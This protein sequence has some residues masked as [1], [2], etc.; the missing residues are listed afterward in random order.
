[1]A[2]NVDSG[3]PAPARDARRPGALWPQISVPLLAVALLVSFVAT[4]DRRPAAPAFSGELAGLVVT[5]RVA[6]DSMHR[7][8]RRGLGQANLGGK[9]STAGISGGHFA[10]R[11]G[12]AVVG[13]ITRAHAAAATLYRTSMRDGITRMLFSVSRP[14]RGGLGQY[15][16]L[17]LRKQRNGTAYRVRL[18]VAPNGVLQ[19]GLSRVRGRVERRI[20][21]TITL[22]VRAPKGRRIVL[23]GIVSGTSPVTLGARA[24]L[25][26]RAA[27]NWQVS[28]TDRSSARLT[29]AGSVGFWTYT[30]RTSRAGTVTITRLDAWSIR[31][32][33]AAPPPSSHDKPSTTPPTPTPTPRPTPSP[34][35]TP[36]PSPSDP[37]PDPTSTP[38]PTPTPTPTPPGEPGSSSTAG[39][40]PVGTASYP[41]SAG[42]LFVSSATGSDSSP[43]TASAPLATVKAAIA[44]AASGQMIVLRGGTYHENLF[45]GS[46]KSVTIEN[47]PDEAVWFDGTTAVPSWSPINGVWVASGWTASFDHSASF[48]KGSDAGGFVNP[49]YPMAAHP[50]QVFIDGRALRQVADGATPGP[51]EFSVNQTAHTL[52]IGSNPSG[53]S[54]RASDLAQAF[55]VAGRITLRGVGVRGYAT[56]LPQIGT[57]YLGGSVGGDVLENVV[58]SDNAT[59]GISA[60]ARNCLLAHVTAQDNGMSGIHSNHG[61]GLVVT[62]SLMT[63]NNTEHFNAAPSAGGIK[64]T[65][66]DGVTIRNNL[67]SENLGI[68]GIWTDVTVSHFS[69]TGNTVTGNGG[70]YG[71]ITELSDTGVVADNVESG[72]KY[73]YTAFDTGN[74]RVFNNSF[75]GNSVWDIG[76]SQDARRNS[77]ANTSATVPWLVRNI[78]VANNVLNSAAGYQFYALDKATHTAVSSMNVTVDGNEFVASSG[79]SSTVMAGWGGADNVTVNRYRTP[80]QLNAGVGK[81]W[82]NVQLSGVQ[83]YAAD[84]AGGSSP[85][86]PLPADIAS[87]IGQPA[88]TRHVGPF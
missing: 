52:S 59:Q 37:T 22:P 83:A 24:W 8:V 50:D 78:V 51:D 79:T 35:P 1:M 15:V 74:V 87:E 7:T 17:E 28:Y 6:A 32:V 42:A 71:I 82:T 43:G 46:T 13:P 69:I 2:P 80:D 76:L 65:N 85:A 60:S 30:S 77:D 27:P 19:L 66:A 40:V 67:I 11:R 44:R 18:R 58:V 31:H 21:R 38:A 62:D 86:V 57:I 4:G 73:G 34:T 3:I 41:V 70:P 29:R 5:G 16:D 45:V 81:S 88:G 20:G 61:S 25:T 48:T 10:V 26:G 23:E 54:V 68:N 56:S 9:Y 14:S 39:S 33:S 55:V 84:Q 12:K 63:G 75:S 64:V 49:T 53:H 72:A 47:Y 36:T